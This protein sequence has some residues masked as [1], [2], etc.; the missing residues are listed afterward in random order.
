MKPTLCV[1]LHADSGEGLRPSSSGQICGHVPGVS[2]GIRTA[3]TIVASCHG[4]SSRAGWARGRLSRSV[5]ARLNRKIWSSADDHTAT[6]YRARLAPLQTVCT[7]RSEPRRCRR[8]F[9][10]ERLVLVWHRLLDLSRWCRDHLKPSV[11]R[12]ALEGATRVI[13]VAAGHWNS[14]N[15]LHQRSTPLRH[16][17]RSWRELFW[18]TWR[19][20]AVPPARLVEPLLLVA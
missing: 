14:S 7:G 13:E 9:R 4:I 15:D 1:L 17:Q 19:R 12:A 16:I 10:S 3:S 6:V 2:S 5:T 20:D 8:V 18:A 11:W